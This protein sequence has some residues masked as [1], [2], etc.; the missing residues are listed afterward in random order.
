[1]K[2][3]FEDMKVIRSTYS[4]VCLLLTAAYWV[5]FLY[6]TGGFPLIESREAIGKVEVPYDQHLIGCLSI[7]LPSHLYSDILLQVPAA[8]GTPC[9]LQY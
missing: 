3:V 4:T 8:I 2:I 5:H 9:Q 7:S 1:M 6:V